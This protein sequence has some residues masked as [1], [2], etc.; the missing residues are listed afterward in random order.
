MLLILLFLN[1]YMVIAP[2]AKNNWN[3]LVW[4]S[5]FLPLATIIV[6]KWES[7]AA[8]VFD[9]IGYIVDAMWFTMLSLLD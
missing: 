7:H 5:T 1:Y 2:L 4:I 9:G 3:Y 8:T 6:Q